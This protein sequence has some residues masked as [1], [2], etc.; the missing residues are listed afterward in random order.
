MWDRYGHFHSL[1]WL[2]PEC[3]SICCLT[4]LPDTF[5][6]SDSMAWSE[7]VAGC[8]E[9]A[10]VCMQPWSGLAM[11]W[12]IAWAITPQ[13]HFVMFQ[14]HFKLPYALK[15]YHVT[16]KTCHN[17]GVS[18]KL[19]HFWPSLVSFLKEWFP[20]HSGMQVQCVLSIWRWP[21]C[22]QTSQWTNWLWLAG[23]VHMTLKTT[24]PSYLLQLW[25][26]LCVCDLPVL[27]VDAI[28]G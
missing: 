27:T 7:C 2:I 22:T 14:R 4:L 17:V 9:L 8:D 5:V 6:C 3:L 1:D 11:G 18:M 25:G 13:A 28:H 15:N 16:T 21:V 20:K 23:C 12:A 24:L 10:T 26:W 19:R